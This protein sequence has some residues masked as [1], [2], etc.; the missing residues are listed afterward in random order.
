LKGVKIVELL[1]LPAVLSFDSVAKLSTEGFAELSNFTFPFFRRPIFVRS[2]FSGN[3]HSV[4][5]NLHATSG[6]LAAGG[7]FTKVRAGD[8]LP[9][10]HKTV[11]GRTP[12]LA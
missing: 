6:G 9:N 3:L 7:G 8:T 12:P 4:T 5:R 1:K 11:C 2:Y 10:S